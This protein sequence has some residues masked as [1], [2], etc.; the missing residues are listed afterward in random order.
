MFMTLAYPA[1]Q[2]QANNSNGANDATITSSVKALFSD[3]KLIG[4]LNIIVTTKDGDVNLQGRVDTDMEFERAITLAES[5]DD[6]KDVKV[7][8][9]KIKESRQPMA[10]TFITAKVNGLILRDKLFT[11]RDVQFWPIKVET[12][13]GVVYLTGTAEN[14]QQINNIV[15]IAKSIEGVTSVENAIIID[16]NNG[17]NGKV[18]NG[19]R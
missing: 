10:D 8:H 12:K 19:N 11:D 1:N 15:A 16:N 9:L 18:N 7:T 13:N 5:V 14:T 4:P 2:K 3:D 17:N 6:V